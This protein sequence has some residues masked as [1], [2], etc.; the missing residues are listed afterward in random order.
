M[1]K[2]KYT[3]KVEFISCEGSFDFWPEEK[4]NDIK[5]KD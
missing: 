1:E 2:R 4:K 5:E 3:G